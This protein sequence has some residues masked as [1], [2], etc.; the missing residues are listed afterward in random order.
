MASKRKSVAPKKCSEAKRRRISWCSPFGI[1]KPNKEVL[2]NDDE[3][4]FLEEYEK[5]LAPPVTKKSP[6]KYSKKQNIDDNSSEIVK[7][8][9]FYVVV[10]TDVFCSKRTLACFDIWPDESSESMNE[11]F[12][13]LVKSSKKLWIYINETCNIQ[14]AYFQLND[15]LTSFNVSGIDYLNV[16]STTSNE[17]DETDKAHTLP[18][19]N[20]TTSTVRYTIYIYHKLVYSN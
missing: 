11:L 3:I 10:F 1:L 12:Y 18:N 6:R 16:V 15:I 8:C 9:S 5:M 4:L 17:T 20:K 19:L 2:I 14:Y 7:N 13:F